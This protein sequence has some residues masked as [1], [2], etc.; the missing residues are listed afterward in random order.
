VQPLVDLGFWLHCCFGRRGTEYASVS[1]IKWMSGGNQ[2]RCERALWPTSA[3][4]LARNAVIDPEPARAAPAYYAHPVA[5]ALLLL[6]LLHTLLHMLLRMLLRLPTGI[7]FMPAPE[8]LLL[9]CDAKQ[10]FTTVKRSNLRTQSSQRGRQPAAPARASQ[11][12]SSVA[13]GLLWLR[14]EVAVPEGLAAAG[15]DG[16]VARHEH[17]RGPPQR[18]AWGRIRLSL[19]RTAQPL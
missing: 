10:P 17:R 11:A 18:R 9:S 15:A 14:T 2:R 4:R 7:L 6:L 3:E 8:L 1:G 19:R 13:G 12:G 16:G 5:P